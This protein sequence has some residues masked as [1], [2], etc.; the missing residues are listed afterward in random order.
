VARR[1]NSSTSASTPHL[2]VSRV[3][4]DRRLEERII[5][6]RE[7]LDRPIAS[8]DDLHIVRDTYYTWHDYN[9]TFLERSFSTSG[10][11]DDYKEWIGIA[12]GGRDL[13]EKVEDLHEDIRMY[14]RRLVS[15][16]ERLELYDEVAQVPESQASGNTG[17][18]S[19]R[20]R[21]PWSKRRA[22]T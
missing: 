14:V 2:T 5:R 9:I 8:N 13:R 19:R 21:R 4:L 18:R 15:L 17:Q 3:G 1:A 22:E 11:A 12:S 16:K 6:R 10:P 7:L 20:L